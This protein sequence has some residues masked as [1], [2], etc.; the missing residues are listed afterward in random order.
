MKKTISL[1]RFGYVGF[2]F[3]LIKGL[4]WMAVLLGFGKLFSNN[5]TIETMKIS[6]YDTYV[7]KKDGTVMH[8][9]I[10]VPDSEKDTAKIHEFGRTYLATKGQAGQPL[11]SKECRFCHIEQAEPDVEQA[12]VSKGYFIIE[13][14]GCN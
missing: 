6:V 13:M 3:F 12:I 11:T 2:A 14:Q 4:I 8:F 9:D 1:K 10:L 5:K 7:K